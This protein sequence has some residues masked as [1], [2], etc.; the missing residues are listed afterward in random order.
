MADSEQEV[1]LD[2][3]GTLGDGGAPSILKKRTRGDEVVVRRPRRRIKKPI[4]SAVCAHACSVRDTDEGVVHKSKKVRLLGDSPEH[5]SNTNADSCGTDMVIPSEG[6][7]KA[8]AIRLLSD[9]EQEF[10]GD[11]TI[12][13]ITGGSCLSS[14][15]TSQNSIRREI[16]TG[17]PHLCA[18]NPTRTPAMLLD[19]A[20]THWIQ[21]SF[22]DGPN[23]DGKDEMG[24]RTV[25][26]TAFGFPHGGSEVVKIKPARWGRLRRFFHEHPEATGGNTFAGLGN[27]T[28]YQCETWEYYSTSTNKEDIHIERAIQLRNACVQPRDFQSVAKACADNNSHWPLVQRKYEGGTDY[29]LSKH[30]KGKGYTNYYSKYNDGFRPI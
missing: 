7:T 20:G 22:S 30:P 23:G 4:G 19:V 12:S 21:G 10:Y 24:F 6:S 2:I 5:Q 28:Y 11:D 3:Q 13:T 25:R 18:N 27:T 1:T 14:W 15:D 8:T 26:F 29:Y 9:S 17:G 16:A